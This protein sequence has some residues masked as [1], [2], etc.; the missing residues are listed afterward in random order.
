MIFFDESTLAPGV[1]VDEHRKL[2]NAMMSLEAS[3]GW[4]LIK[5]ELESRMGAAYA[6]MLEAKTGDE[7]LKAS[8]A[9]T[10]IKEIL[11][12]PEKT[13]KSSLS[14]LAILEAEVADL[15]PAPV[16]HRA[17]PGMTFARPTKK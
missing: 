13:V 1:A 15:D 8:T 4:K 7:S 16:H 12:S 6:T 3:Q 5:G 14:R 11:E 9:Y 2:A 10:T 17:G